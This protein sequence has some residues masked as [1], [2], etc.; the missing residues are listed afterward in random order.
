M[1]SKPRG[2]CKVPSASSR[3]RD[4]LAAAS[5]RGTVCDN[6]PAA[7][8]RK[9]H[10]CAGGGSSCVGSPSP[11]TGLLLPAGTCSHPKSPCPLCMVLTTQTCP[12]QRS[13]TAKESLRSPSGLWWCPHLVIVQL[14]PANSVKEGNFLLLDSCISIPAFQLVQLHYHPKV[15]RFELEEIGLI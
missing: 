10:T 14:N 1:F 7:I 3:V 9:P 13:R 2:N 12:Q 6:S 15:F 4:L 11:P 8:C 5:T